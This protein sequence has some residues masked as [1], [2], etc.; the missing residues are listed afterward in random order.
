[1]LEKLEMTEKIFDRT[2]EIETIL[3]KG[4]D[5]GEA[6]LH[7]CSNC[8]H[9]EISD[10]NEINYNCPVC[11][12]NKN[13]WLERTQDIRVK[14]ACDFGYIEKVKYDADYF[15]CVIVQTKITVDHKEGKYI[16]TKNQDKYVIKYVRELNKSK[17]Y[18]MRGYIYKNNN[19]IKFLKENIEKIQ[20]YAEDYRSY[21]KQINSYTSN[22]LWDIYKEYKINRDF[23]LYK[24]N[25]IY[26]SYNNK[27]QLL[28]NMKSSES[29]CKSVYEYLER[30]KDN[31]VYWFNLIAYLPNREENYY[32]IRNDLLNMEEFSNTTNILLLNHYVE[33]FIRFDY[34]SQEQVDF[35]RLLQRQGVLIH[36]TTVVKRICD[37][38]NDL[39]N[40][41]MDIEIEKLPKEIEI[42]LSRS[43]S[44]VSYYNNCKNAIFMRGYN[45][46]N[47]D[48]LSL[49]D[50]FYDIV[51]NKNEL[52]PYVLKDYR[53][54]QVY[55]LAIK[56]TDIILKVKFNIMGK[57]LNYEI[58]GLYKGIELIEDLD[59]IE[60]ILK[61]YHKE[62]IVNG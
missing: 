20:N 54:E 13:K 59:K 32:K 9:T 19:R 25:H 29:Y 22:N 17:K 40:A 38:Y 18:V 27:E 14:D 12:T 7:Y 51:L 41:G 52:V 37:I 3:L 23:I 44:I 42:Y 5:N 6:Y 36:E 47:L 4:L 11:N 35:I 43:I 56:N 15:E 53:M 45:Y 10:N 61:T 2:K 34:N 31:R 48:T 21:L 58:K 8:E 55:C 60:E 49:K 16:L 33:H 30:H 57:S 26:A 28:N 1:M 24:I 46:C 39:K 62:E 50:T